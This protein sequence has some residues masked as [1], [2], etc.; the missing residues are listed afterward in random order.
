MLTE[1]R[2]QAVLQGHLNTPQPCPGTECAPAQ[3][4]LITL[5][6]RASS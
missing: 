3:A 4:A 5:E 2:K 1:G 6:L